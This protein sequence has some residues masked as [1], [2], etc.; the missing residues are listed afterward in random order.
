MKV[1]WSEP[2]YRVAVPATILKQLGGRRFIAM[3]GSKHFAGTETSLTMKLTRNK[4]GATH[5]KIN[6][7]PQ[8]WY[9][10]TFMKCHINQRGGPEILQEVDEVYFD[11]LQ[12]VFT[13]C[14]GLY[15]SL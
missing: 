15:T 11:R 6:L 14:T 7:E 1:E 2:T 4:L 12:E 8:D 9:K 5:L 3:T 10:L 13:E